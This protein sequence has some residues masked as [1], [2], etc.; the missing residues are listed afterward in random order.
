MKGRSVLH[1]TTIRFF[2]R[3]S[4]FIIVKEV[5]KVLLFNQTNLDSE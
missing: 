4:G 5:A 2:L 3:F 1:S